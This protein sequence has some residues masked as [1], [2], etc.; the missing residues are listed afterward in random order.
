MFSATAAAGEGRAAAVHAAWCPWWFTIE[1]AEVQVGPGGLK[2]VQVVD[3]GLGQERGQMEQEW[4]TQCQQEQQQRQQQERTG[5]LG[6]L[7]EQDGQQEQIEQGGKAALSHSN[8]NTTTSR[9]LLLAPDAAAGGSGCG[10]GV[11]G[12]SSVYGT[13]GL[14]PFPSS[15]IPALSALTKVTPSPLVRWTL[16]QLLFGYSVIMRHFSGELHGSAVEAACKLLAV[17]PAVTP[18][19]TAADGTSGRGT[20]AVD[21][22][23]VRGGSKGEVAATA[24]AAGGGGGKGGA[25]VA[26][27]ASAV[28]GPPESVRVALQQSMSACYAPEADLGAAIGGGLQPLVRAATADVVLLLELGRAS[29]LLAAHHVLLWLQDAVGEVKLQLEQY[30]AMATELERRSDEQKQQK[31]KQQEQKQHCKKEGSAAS[32]SAAGTRTAAAA[33]SGGGGEGEGRGRGK[34]TAVA[35][36]VRKGEAAAGSRE[37]SSSTKSVMRKG[38]AGSSSSSSSKKKEK[39]QL[40]QLVQRLQGALHKV[41]YLLSWANEQPQGLWP[42][43]AAAV[44]IEQQQL[45]PGGGR[46]VSPGMA[47]EVSLVSLPPAAS[48]MAGGEG[49]VVERKSGVGGGLSCCLGAHQSAGPGA[50]TCAKDRGPADLVHVVQPNVP[51]SRQSILTGRA[52]FMEE[53]DAGGVDAE[54]VDAKVVDAKGGT[55]GLGAVGLEPSRGVDG[56]VR[57]AKPQPVGKDHGGGGDLLVVGSRDSPVNEVGQQQEQ[58]GQWQ[59]EQK[60]Q[61]Q[62]QQAGGAALIGIDLYGLD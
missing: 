10:G 13:S 28:A 21:D 41:A 59:Y 42:S 12:R 43:L 44:A 9:K 55:C 52:A 48:A 50:S 60:D 16:V 53:I 8:A 58:Q 3:Q 56:G 54:G 27:A 45:Y 20:A 31:Q 61:Q 35:L 23:A 4:E 34:I 30:K 29:V 24:A 38:V 47:P 51:A 14:P 11:N 22:G 18:A 5:V 36:G 17:T 7:N 15:A 32:L 1:A 2:L 33:V 62:K 46:A 25:G 40:K 39:Q 49:L 37:P 6:S 19:V 26:A 57:K